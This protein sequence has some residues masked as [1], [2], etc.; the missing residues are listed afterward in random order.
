M[1]PM[2]T[3][4]SSLQKQM[5]RA[6]HTVTSQLRTL[7]RERTDAV[8][9]AQE[10]TT[11]R[12]LEVSTGENSPPQETAQNQPPD[13]Q[14]IGQEAITVVLTALRKGGRLGNCERTRFFIM[15]SFCARDLKIS[16]RRGVWAQPRNEQKQWRL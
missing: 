11:A 9:A 7:M 5:R 16:A 12:K 8:N 2:K 10:D 13:A 15:K 6:G 14:Q 3:M 4:L 1:V